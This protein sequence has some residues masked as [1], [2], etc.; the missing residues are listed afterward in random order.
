MFKNSTQKNQKRYRLTLQQPSANDMRST[1]LLKVL[2]NICP[3]IKCGSMMLKP[4]PNVDAMV[5]RF[6]IFNPPNLHFYRDEH[7]T[8]PTRPSMDMD[9]CK[10]TKSKIAKGVFSITDELG[11]TTHLMP[12]PDKYMQKWGWKDHV[13]V[14]EGR[15]STEIARIICS[16]NT[17][18]YDTV[19]DPQEVKYM[20]F[21]I[22]KEHHI[23]FGLVLRQLQGDVSVLSA[24][25]PRFQFARAPLLY[26]L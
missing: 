12:V 14:I 1:R 6:C 13:R 9:K 16:W 7:K 2:R 26:V 23:G 22:T 15:R 3:T 25:M 4:D 18:S 5:P 17:S 20:R 11:T 21:K 24:S 8:D 19:I 10:V